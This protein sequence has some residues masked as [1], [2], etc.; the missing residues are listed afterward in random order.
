MSRFDSMALE[1]SGLSKQLQTTQ[2]SVDE[3]RMKQ[4]EVEKLKA[5]AP[6]PIPPAPDE[7]M[8]GGSTLLGMPL[9]MPRLTNGMQPLLVQPGGNQ[10]E[11]PVAGN[12]HREYHSVPSSSR[13][14]FAKPPKHDF[15]KFDGTNPHMWFDLCKTYF[16]MYSVP[17]HQWTSVASL[18]F[19]G[20][21]A[22]WWQAYKR[23]H[24]VSS[25]ESLCAAIA[26]EF[27]QDDYDV[28]M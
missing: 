27:G 11:R 3:V 19:S 22:L 8:G 10:E 12:S 2:E 5:V 25:W 16:D 9:G 6:P 24:A 20:H 14:F 15:P 13:E 21:A 28:L 26:L 17:Q 23:C 1:I 7:P 18:Y 4:R